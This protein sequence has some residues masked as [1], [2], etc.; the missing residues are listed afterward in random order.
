MK[1]RI[2]W[3]QDAK[4]QKLTVNSASVH[5]DSFS[6]AQPTALAGKRAVGRPRRLTLDAIV[7]AACLVGIERLEMCTV[8]QQLNTGVAT[9]YGYVRGRDH[10]LELV[11]ERMASRAISDNYGGTWQ[12]VLHGHA[13]LCFAMFNSKPEMIGNLI[14]GEKT[15]REVA[16]AT[17]IIAML[18][19]RGL[20]RELALNLYVEA[21]QAVIGAAVML[22][23]RKILA[24]AGVDE[25][26]NVIALPPG[27][28][29]YRPTLDRIVRG[30]EETLAA[31]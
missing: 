26:G 22:V 3:V 6:P 19:K 7:D 13:A 4:E 20:S 30:C 29:D 15:D 8:A 5:D 27:L 16:Y 31:G 11:A 17:N 9:L 24:N 10:L 18:E 25:Q 12:E 23:R 21:N 2:C 1:K 14:G 28:G